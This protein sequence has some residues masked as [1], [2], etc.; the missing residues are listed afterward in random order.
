MMAS[1]S[2]SP[3]TPIAIPIPA[4]AHRPA[5]V[6][7]PL[8]APLGSWIPTAA[9]DSQ[10]ER[11]GWI[12]NPKARPLLPPRAAIVMSSDISDLLAGWP[13]DGDDGIQV[14]RIEGRDGK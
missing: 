4:T 8:T 2:R 11:R 14:R 13:Y 12:A 3:P 9:A 1:V 6:V 10:E 5:A 7:R